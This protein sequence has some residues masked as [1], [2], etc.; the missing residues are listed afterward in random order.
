MQFSDLESF[1]NNTIKNQKFDAVIV[2][3][4]ND[5]DLNALS[6]LGQVQELDIDYLL[7]Y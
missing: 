2:G 5:V 7:N 6:Q 4:R 1:F 3:N